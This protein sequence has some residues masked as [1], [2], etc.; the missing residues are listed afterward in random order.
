MPRIRISRLNWAILA[1][2][3]AFT[4]VAQ[5]QDVRIAKSDAQID[6]LDPGIKLFVREKMAEGNTT[7]TDQNIVLFL[8][9]ATACPFRKSYPRVA[10]MQSG[11]DWC[12][13][14]GPRSL[15]RSS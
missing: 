15:D 10:M 9:G 6:G 7:F 11:Q 3:L 1:V 5:A 12:D 2:A 14:N 8:H 4:H 13:H